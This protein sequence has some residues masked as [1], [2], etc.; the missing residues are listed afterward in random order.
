MKLTH[1]RNA[2]YL[3]GKIGEKRSTTPEGF[4]VCHDVPIARTGTQLYTSDEVPIE[5]GPD[6]LVRI[7]R[8]ADEVFSQATISS[9]EGKPVTVN[10]PDEFVNPEN[11]KNL[12]VGF[13]Q[14]VRR[15]DG[16]FNDLL[17]A[18]L[19]ITDADGIEYVN[20]ELPEVSCGYEADYEQT[21]AGYGMQLN[22]I[23]NHVA[24]VDRGRAGSRCAI[25]DSAPTEDKMGK[26]KK[27]WLD[28]LRALVKDAEAEEKE[29]EKEEEEEEV[30]DE[31]P[32][33][34]DEGQEE[35]KTSDAD[36]FEQ[37]LARL[38]SVINK[39]IPME[40][41]EHGQQ[42]DADPE[43]KEK[44]EETV[45]TIIEPEEAD[46][47]DTGTV[48]TGDSLKAVIARAEILAP[49]IAIP[50]GDAAKGKH[51]VPRLQLKA[52]Q[53]AMTTADGKAIVKPFL[54]G[55]KLGKLTFDQL[56][57][58]FTG[59]AEL[60][61]ARNNAS[62]MSSTPTKDFGKPASVEAINA[63]NKEFWAKNK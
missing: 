33:K 9:F 27:N 60:M 4:L 3:T 58:V 11:W 5:P 55:R 26:E 1:D 15:G 48:L 17:L 29:K 40:E 53:T 20:R 35:K 13:V 22:I 61:R 63:K 16:I 19:V 30:K 21:D 52:I 49:G 23:G 41:A 59:A 18:D 38:E 50:T 14:N 24:L 28:R 45:D 42:L 34:E 31:F 46:K 7:G 43:E 25:Q 51:V 10:H 2:F 37:R 56:S 6:G 44:E 12:T 54:M 8:D 62:L 36:V 47:F 39:L 57:M 32:D